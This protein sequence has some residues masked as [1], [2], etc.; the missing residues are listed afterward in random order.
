MNPETIN[1]LFRKRTGGL[2]HWTRTDD[3]LLWKKR[4]GRVRI[5]KAEFWARGCVKMLYFK[6]ILSILLVIGVCLH[7]MAGRRVK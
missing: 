6:N 7:L 1:R 3:L 5:G 2:L 4:G